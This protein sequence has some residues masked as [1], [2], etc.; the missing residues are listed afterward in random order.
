MSLVLID[1]SYGIGAL[2]Q[3][4]MAHVLLLTGMAHVDNERH[5]FV[6]KC[7]VL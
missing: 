1:D 2:T 5:R 4:S 6:N 7:G 3:I